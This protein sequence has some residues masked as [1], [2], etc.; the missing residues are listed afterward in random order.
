VT[1][2]PFF[3]LPASSFHDGDLLL[4]S[5]SSI[6]SRPPPRPPM[7]CPSVRAHCPPAVRDYNDA[8]AAASPHVADPSTARNLLY[9]PELLHH[10]RSPNPNIDLGLHHHRRYR[11]RVAVALPSHHRPFRLDA[12]RRLF[13]LKHARKKGHHGLGRIPSHTNIIAR[14]VRIRILDWQ[15]LDD[16]AR[17]VVVEPVGPSG[18]W[19]PFHLSRSHFWHTSS[20]IFTGC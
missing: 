12:V 10:P 4:S 15:K 11:S 13:G 8:L 5:S 2:F 7:P 3:L 14:P 6:D 1:P 20:R 16:D 17:S 9:T 18:A 19:A